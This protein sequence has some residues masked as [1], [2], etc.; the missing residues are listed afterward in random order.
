MIRYKWIINY[1]KWETNIVS[2]EGIYTDYLDSPNEK[3]IRGWIVIS[4]PILALQYTLDIGLWC[5]KVDNTIKREISLRKENPCYIR[6]RNAYEVIKES[7]LMGYYKAEDRAVIRLNKLQ[8]WEYVEGRQVEDIVDREYDIRLLDWD[9]YC[10]RWQEEEEESDWLDE[11][12]CQ[13]TVV[14]RDIPIAGFFKA[15]KNQ[16]FNEDIYESR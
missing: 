14:L 4:I 10:K 2:S 1:K 3:S 9:S 7:A 15:V 6:G 16:K 11:E 12:D 5:S 13:S 8:T